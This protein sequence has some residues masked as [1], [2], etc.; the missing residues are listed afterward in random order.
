MR[1]LSGATYTVFIRYLVIVTIQANNIILS[2][3]CDILV[4]FHSLQNATCLCVCLN[5]QVG[6][7]WSQ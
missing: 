3:N 6:Q 2:V 4:Y 5:V 1:V 7:S